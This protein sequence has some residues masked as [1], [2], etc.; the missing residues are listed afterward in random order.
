M[1]A[2][3]V[4][5]L[6]LLLTTAITGC[7]EHGPTLAPLAGPAPVVVSPN[8][9]I[10]APEGAAIS[11]DATKGGATFAGIVAGAARYAI[12]F[13]TPTNGL[14][15]VGATVV[16]TPSAPGVTRAILVA[17]DP[18]GRFASDTFAIVVFAA[19][20][21]APV[22]PATPLSY[23]DIDHPLPAHYRAAVDGL[24]ATA[25]DNTPPDNPI[26]NAG[27]ALGRVLFYDPRLSGN[28]G[29]SCAGCHSPFIAFSDSPQ[30]SVGFAGGLTGRHSPSLVNA[31][32][33][34]R[35]RFFWDERAGTLEAQVLRPVQDPTEMGMSL[36][37]L[38]T[39]LV[40]TPYY[41]PLFTS[42]FGTP[43]VT[44][45]RIARALAQ[46]VRALTSTG[47]RYDRAFSAAGVANFASVFTAQELEGERLF[48]S[49]GCAS[50]HTTVAMV[51][52]S[53]HNIGL[54]VVTA[55]SGAGRGAFKA[56]S[57]RNVALR[58]RFMHD[59]RFTSL[60]QVV[61]F[62]NA[63]VQANPDLDARLRAADGT[64]RRLGLTDTQSA[65]LV[66]FLGTLT[67][68]T[69]AIAPRFA[70]PFAP[71]V[72]PTLPP[73]PPA[74]AT[75]F[76]AIQGTAYQPPNIT[77][78]G[79]TVVIWTNFDNARHTASFDS[80]LIGSTPVFRTGVQSLTMPSAS[81]TYTYHC[82]IHGAAMSGTVTVR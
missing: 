9:A 1:V 31:R 63:G 4:H 26:T 54:D 47:S 17:T 29:V 42:A 43:T 16:G 3:H 58:P 73:I 57:L 55:D 5:R 39:K 13:I 50:C 10:V 27:A 53:V 12:T 72:T 71:A 52:D 59:G 7:D 69:F 82:A 33:Y 30:R 34:T 15:A 64:P 18:I 11:Y 76:V 78:A 40:V 14:S 19:G 51:S 44:S 20:L 22:L 41:A 56:P 25:T 66:A 2:R 81:G 45:D 61:A 67:D 49:S 28:D 60:E 77:V 46:Y 32:F 21:T 6:A 68:S 75:V 24:V 37:N 38:V 8:V 65:A 36:D 74:T 23:A 80:G 70:N 62:F 79:S 48:R 35:G